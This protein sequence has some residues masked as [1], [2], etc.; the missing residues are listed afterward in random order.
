MIS[1]PHSL[2]VLRTIGSRST[3]KEAVG[4]LVEALARMVV[5]R[6]L[7]Q[8]AEYMHQRKPSTHDRSY[9]SAPF[10]FPGPQSIPL[11]QLQI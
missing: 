3:P 5:E 7:L 4:F 6:G 11:G 2:G 10:H 1:F 9:V 8:D